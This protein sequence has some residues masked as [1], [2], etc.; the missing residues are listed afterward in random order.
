M[1]ANSNGGSNYFYY[2]CYGKK[3]LHK[4]CH[5]RNLRKD[6]IE[7]LVVQDAMSLL[8]DER[9]EEIA[10][11]AVRN[12]AHDIETTT[13]IPAIRTKLHETQISLANITKAIETGL[14]PETLVKRMV[15]L[16]KD[17]KAL[18]SELKKEEKSVVCLDKAQVLYWLEQFKD[19]DIEDE[20]FRRLLVDLFVNSVTVWDE[21]DD[22]F[23]VTIAYN[24]TSLKE[25]TYRLQK[26]GTS[27]DLALN[28]PSLQIAA[29]LFPD[30]LIQL[31][32]KTIAF[33]NRNEY[34]R[35]DQT[36]FRIPPAH[37]SFCADKSVCGQVVLR[38]EPDFKLALCE[39]ISHHTNDLLRAQEAFT[40]GFII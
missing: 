3:N 20:D 27:S 25:K 36:F 22:F 15:E 30:E 35:G 9:I 21:P 40:H 32:N 12:S 26:G 13:D 31:I 33:K 16:E 4:D 18:E 7:D 28:A 29:G 11:V 14:A 2:E 8:T 37:E 38:L 1:N 39:S 19:G 23:K 5:K 24:L 6:F 10:E 17:K 34:P